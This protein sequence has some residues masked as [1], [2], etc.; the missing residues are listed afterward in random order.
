MAKK[1]T[2][3]ELEK[4]IQELKLSEIKLKKAERRGLE[5]DYKYQTVISNIPGMVYR[6]NSDWSTTIIS[7]SEIVCGY[8]IE[9]FNTKKINWMDLIHPDDKKRVIEEHGLSEKKKSITQEYR[10]VTKDGHTRWL[11]DHKTVILGDKEAIVGVDGVVFD[12]TERKQILGRTEQ[13]NSL[14]ERLLVS[15]GLNYKVKLITE[16][17]I[18]IFKADFARI[19]IIRSGDLC[20]SECQHA[21]IA[22]GPNACHYRE[23]CLH[24]LASSGRYTHI[25][26]GHRRVP[27]G[28]FKIGKVASGDESKFL[29]NDVVNDPLVSDHEWAIKLGLVSFAGYRLL[30]DDGGVIGVLA[31]FSKQAI[32]PEEDALLENLAATTTHI[33]QKAKTEEALRESEKKYRIIYE[34]AVEGFFQSTP[35]GRFV[36]VNSAFSNMLGYDSPEDLVSSISDITTQYYVNP[37]DRKRYKKILKDN[38]IVENFEFKAKRKDGS[39]IWVSNSTR[40]YF[41]SDGRVIRYE[42]IVLDITERKQIEETLQKSHKQFLRVLDGIDATIYVV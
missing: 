15:G 37:D 7:N 28:S 41:D 34:N 14:N 12:I 30:S 11:S 38:G 10:I 36:S 1:P 21:K 17:I 9:E 13:L 27:F 8:S 6:G 39:A 19:W 24:L 18:K 26:G 42:G 22:E 33:I 4:R 25:D 40:A 35:E 23:R 3:E 29:T 5:N 31:L 32:S 2:Y 20:D 16:E